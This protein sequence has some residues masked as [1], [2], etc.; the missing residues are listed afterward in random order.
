MTTA[1]LQ[2]EERRL[3]QFTEIESL[4]MFWLVSFALYSVMI[5]NHTHIETNDHVKFA[6]GL[7]L[8]ARLAASGV[9][10]LI[11]IYGCL[12]NAR[13]RKAFCYFPCIWVLGILVMHV[14]GTYFSPDFNYSVAHLTT[15]MCVGLFAPTA[16]AVLGSR[17]TVNV[18]VM[19]MLTTVVA[20]WILYLFAPAYGVMIEITDSTGASVERMGGTS[21]P[22]VLAGTCVLLFVTLCY[23]WFERKMGTFVAVPLILLTVATLFM[24]GTRV[25]MISGVVSVLFVYRGFW[26]QREILPFTV[27][28]TAVGLAGVGVVLS[29]GI[30][31]DAATSLTR[32]GDFDEITSVTGRSDIWVYVV[33][34]IGERP[35]QGYGPGTAKTLL[36]KKGMLLHPH[37]LLLHMAVN[38]GII[39]AFFALMMLINQF[40]I[41]LTGK[42]KLAALISFVIILNSF[43]EIPIFDYVPGAP[44]I[45]WMVAIFWPFLDDGTL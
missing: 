40:F 17:Q 16:L 18:M 7:E 38:G 36:D 31:S 15:V 3:I 43:T 44:T 21:H 8:F 22:N 26:L 9:A 45:M 2:P 4:A 28:L 30:Q 24:T 32:S 25:A 13:V 41:S 39:C 20:S 11:G 42:Y 5:V 1:S 33:E 19:A 27:L 12:F 6:G 37:N 29:G 35:L 10:G 34:L 14:V 23:L